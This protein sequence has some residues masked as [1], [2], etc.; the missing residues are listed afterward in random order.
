MTITPKYVLV[1]EVGFWMSV[2]LLLSACGLESGGW[3]GYDQ[4]GLLRLTWMM[5]QIVSYIDNY[6][7]YTFNIHVSYLI[8]FD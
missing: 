6:S 1:L 4:Y 5:P 2:C 3:C 8:V 7:K